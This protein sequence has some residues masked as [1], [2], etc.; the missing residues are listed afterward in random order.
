MLARRLVEERLAACASVLPGLRST[1]RW[2]GAIQ[3]G[4]EVLLLAKT[5]AARFDALAARIVELHPYSVPAVVAVEVAAGLPAY[6]AWV[7]AETR[8]ADPVPAP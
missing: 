2:D 5:S 6:L 8:G 1:W 4:D 7:D 3:E